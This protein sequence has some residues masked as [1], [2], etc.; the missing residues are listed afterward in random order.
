M[1]AEAVVAIAAVEPL[2]EIG[3]A[4]AKVFPSN[5]ELS[6]ARA[7]SA[8]NYLQNNASVEA[9][10][11]SA[12]GHGEFK[13]IADNSTPEGREQNRRIELILRR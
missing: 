2:K 12:R 8:V 7:A 4:L 1:L 11:L 9:D 10:R 3:A 5:W 13:P 6:V